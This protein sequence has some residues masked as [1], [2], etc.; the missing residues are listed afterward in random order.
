MCKTH[1]DVTARARRPPDSCESNPLTIPRMNA[2]PALAPGAA[3]HAIGARGHAVMRAERAREA[4]CVLE[5]ALRADLA[6]RQIGARQ[7]VGGRTQAQA[8]CHFTRSLPIQRM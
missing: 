8:R 3:R 1:A 6:D 2:L 4:A 5:G 7:Q